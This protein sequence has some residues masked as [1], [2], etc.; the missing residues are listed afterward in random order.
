MSSAETASKE[1]WRSIAFA[2]AQKYGIAVADFI[3]EGSLKQPMRAARVE[4]CYRMTR[5]TQFSLTMIARIAKLKDHTTV[6]YCSRRFGSM[7]GDPDDV[8][9]MRCKTL[10]STRS[11]RKTKATRGKLKPFEQRGLKSNLAAYMS[12]EAKKGGEHLVKA[13]RYFVRY[14]PLSGCLVRNVV[15][16]LSSLRIARKTSL[17]I[18]GV[19]LS[20][21]AVFWILMTGERPPPPVRTSGWQKGFRADSTFSRGESLDKFLLRKA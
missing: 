7:I 14:D 11:H 2:T 13:T 12:A 21:A 3:R 15:L 1:S 19:Q 8:E 5:E 20:G 17:N 6:Y 10:R 16:T 4:F 9:W 18:G